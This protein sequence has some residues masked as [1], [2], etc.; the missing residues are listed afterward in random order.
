MGFICKTIVRGAVISAV[1][2]GAAVAVA[3]PSRIRAL[4]HSCQSLINY[5][6]DSNI[7]DP[8]ALR[9]HLHH[10]EEQYPKRIADVRGDLA[11]LNEQITQLERELAVSKKVV[12]M[13]DSDLSQMQ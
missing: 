8:T 9:A 11:E 4:F 12:T 10:L 13:A 6:I 5:A 1:V 3:G 7:I 2:G